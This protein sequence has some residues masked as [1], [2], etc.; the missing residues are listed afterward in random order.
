MRKG[1][2][3]ERGKEEKREKR[4]EEKEKK[5]KRREEKDRDR[6]NTLSALCLDIW[7]LR[8]PHRLGGGRCEPGWVCPP[9]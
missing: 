9:D 8:G 6:E 2:R 4:G 7:P 1:E 5:R 3:G